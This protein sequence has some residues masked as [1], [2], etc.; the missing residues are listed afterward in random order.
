MANL[1]SADGVRQMIHESAKEQVKAELEEMAD[2][3]CEDLRRKL[4]AKVDSLALS[5]LSEYDVQMNAERVIISV[6]KPP[7][8]ESGHR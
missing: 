2:K 1:F 3:A 7:V 4:L 6:K 8:T 5:I